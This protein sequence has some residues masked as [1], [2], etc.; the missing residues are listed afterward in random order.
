MEKALNGGGNGGQGAGQWM[1]SNVDTKCTG[2]T[3]G[4]L[5]GAS[6]LLASHGAICSSWFLNAPFMLSLYSGIDLAWSLLPN[7][8]HTLSPSWTFQN[9]EYISPG[10]SLEN[11]MIRVWGK[12]PDNWHQGKFSS[13]H[14]CSIL[15]QRLSILN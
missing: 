3:R 15:N 12:Y 8:F 1:K 10:Y 13:I 14:S 2:L 9:L 7:M 6:V 11:M 4:C 5:K